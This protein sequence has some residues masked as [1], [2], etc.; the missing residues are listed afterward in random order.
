[1]TGSVD[2]KPACIKFDRWP[3]IDRMLWQEGCVAE[4]PF[5]PGGHGAGLRPDSLTKIRKGY[6]V[7]LSFLAARGE[8]DPTQSPAERLTRA[9]ATAYLS[10]LRTLGR[11]GHTILGR[12]GELRMAM[13]IM[14]PDVDTAWLLKPRGVSLRS[15]IRPHSRSV[16]VPDSAVAFRWGL[17]LMGEAATA[18][19]VSQGLARYR[20]GLMIALL[21]ARARRLR[22]MALIRVDKELQFR[23]GRY[24]V[25][26]EPDQVKTGRPD[27]F[28]VPE[29]LTEAMRHY[30]DVVRP[31]LLDGSNDDA[32]WIS[33][34][35]TKLTERAIQAMLVRRSRRRFGVAFSTHRFR[36]MVA[37]TLPLRRPDR[38][39]LGAA[40]LGV[41]KQVVEQHYNRAG[42]IRAAM[43]YQELL[44]EQMAALEEQ[45]RYR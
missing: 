32:L 35:G 1:M 40:V 33:V 23:D 3:E 43:E 42:Q 8:L 12:F 15:I 2:W 5:S 25:Q 11:S 44:A 19:W 6:G 13:R 7:W 45:Y 30:L 16:V 9:R 38:P 14:A 28:L 41:S 10:A 34:T 36:H 22:S 37:T 24:Y 31:A 27:R 17:D 26:F 18:S 20:D 29:T 21:A 39:G 4:T